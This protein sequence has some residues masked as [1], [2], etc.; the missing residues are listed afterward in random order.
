M[1]LLFVLNRLASA[2]INADKVTLSSYSTFSTYALTKLACFNRGRLD[3][4]D[5]AFPLNSAL[6]LIGM[7]VFFIQ[8]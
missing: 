5:K 1:L 2:L 6:A 3:K 4:K 8:V 7:G